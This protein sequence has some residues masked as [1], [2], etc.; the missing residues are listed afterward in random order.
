MFR[1]FIICAG[2]FLSCTAA[3]AQLEQLEKNL[4]LGNTTK[5]SDSKVASGLKEAL[6]VG[7]ENSVKLAGRGIWPENR[8]LCPQHESLC[9]SRRSRRK[10]NLHRR[11]SGD[12]L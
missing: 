5:L 10:K 6:K 7:A 11:D 9:R 8:F 3:H 1:S 12:E 4:G 2:I